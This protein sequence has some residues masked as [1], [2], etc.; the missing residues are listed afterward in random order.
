[1]VKLRIRYKMWLEKDKK[2]IYGSGRQQLLEEVGKT[3]SLAAAA[4][5]M[6]MSYRAAWGRMKASEKRLGF[7]L[8]E[9]GPKGRRG[10]QL[11]SQARDFIRRYAELTKEMDQLLAKA[12]KG[13]PEDLDED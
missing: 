8:V 7:T 1:M 13:W 6:G 12:K 3:G 9:P 5:E 11:T 4:R 2:V 10:M